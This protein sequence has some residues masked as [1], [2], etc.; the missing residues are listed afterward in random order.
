MVSV[1]AWRG[2]FVFAFTYA[3]DPATIALGPLKE[4][5]VYAS[6]TAILV[7]ATFWLGVAGK[8]LRLWTLKYVKDHK[9]E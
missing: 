9:L 8:P 2:L 5:A 6:L 7:L 4:Y 3:L 1:C